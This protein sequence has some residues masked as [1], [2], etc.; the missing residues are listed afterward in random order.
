ML[1]KDK[2]LMWF[3]YPKNTEFDDKIIVFSDEVSESRFWFRDIY[4]TN[5]PKRIIKIIDTFRESTI[6]YSD[7]L[8]GTDFKQAIDFSIRK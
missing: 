6:F 1:Q 3:I 5:L 4:Q 7:D 8:T 2:N